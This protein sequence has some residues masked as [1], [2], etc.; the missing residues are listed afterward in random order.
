M[1]S[2]NTYSLLNQLLPD[3]QCRQYLLQRNKAKGLNLTSQ[4][5]LRLPFLSPIRQ[6]SIHPHISFALAISTW[7]FESNPRIYRK[8]CN[9]SPTRKMIFHKQTRTEYSEQPLVQS[10]NIKQK[11]PSPHLQSY[12]GLGVYIY[13]FPILANLYS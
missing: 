11:T 13:P 8:H 12:S 6:P 1:R 4:H 5:I 9:L 10:D 3:P 2:C 7:S